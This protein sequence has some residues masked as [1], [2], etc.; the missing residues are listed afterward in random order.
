[1]GVSRRV[2]LHGKPGTGKTFHAVNA[3]IAED[4]PVYQ[5]TMTDETPM[6][7]LRGHYIA[8][9]S[10]WVWVDGPA[11]IAWRKGARLVVN[12]IDRASEDALS[13]LYVI[14][15]D[16]EFAKTTLP[17][18]EVIAPASGFQVVATMNGVPEDLPEALQDRF[19]VDIEITD[20]HPKAL[21]QLPEDLQEPAKNSTQARS[22]GRRLSI[23]SWLEFAQLREKLG[24]QTAA[25]AIF[26]IEQ[27]ENVLVAL[28]VAEKASEGQTLSGIDLSSSINQDA[29][30]ALRTAHKRMLD[31][32]TDA[33]S[34]IMSI[35]DS[36]IGLTY[37]HEGE[38]LFIN[39]GFIKKG[40]SGTSTDPADVILVRTDGV[41]QALS[42]FAW[43]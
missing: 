22:D 36:I 2:L 30:L 26:G 20:I 12:E 32:V 11:T 18:G 38:A 21:E 16:P 10:E 15:D 27:A 35:N 29:L 31:G 3:G 6:A 14:M 42:E 41:H 17:T 37:K 25:E 34:T 4:Q 39:A 9:G 7:E 40:A 23:R 19:P 43:E 5:I 33:Q 1:M 13:F 28:R 8:K 24:A